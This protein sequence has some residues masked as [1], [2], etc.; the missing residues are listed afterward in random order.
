MSFNKQNLIA[1][2]GRME[3]RDLIISLAKIEEQIYKH[4]K[5]GEG[6][7]NSKGFKLKYSRNVLRELLSDKLLEWRMNKSSGNKPELTYSKILE[8]EQKFLEETEGEE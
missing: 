6:A 4:I 7:N 3:L 8:K 5:L 1:R 2:Y